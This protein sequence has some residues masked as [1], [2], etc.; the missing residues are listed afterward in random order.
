MPIGSAGGDLTEIEMVDIYTDS[1]SQ[2]LKILGDWG[3]SGNCTMPD[4]QHAC[5]FITTRVTIAAQAQ[6]PNG[7][8]DSDKGVNL[9]NIRK[10]WS[11][12]LDAKGITGR[13][14]HMRWSNSGK[15]LC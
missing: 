10:T 14:A 1:R 5:Y 6:A 4:N 3:L 11:V 8:E 15:V 13:R 12:N 7:G 9:A 2:N